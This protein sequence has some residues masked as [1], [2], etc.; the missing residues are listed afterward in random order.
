MFGVIVLPKFASM[1][2]E[3]IRGFGVNSLDKIMVLN[4]FQN[5]NRFNSQKKNQKQFTYKNPFVSESDL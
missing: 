2:F 4:Q 5:Q 3:T 1:C